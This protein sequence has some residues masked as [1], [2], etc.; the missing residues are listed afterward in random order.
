MNAHRRYL[1][2]VVS[3]V[4]SLDLQLTSS[5]RAEVMHLVDHGEPAEGL[6]TLA[7]IIHDESKNPKAATLE[8]L[9]ELIDGLVETQHLPPTIAAMRGA[10]H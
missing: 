4:D 9:M 8:K 3:L 7:W 2:Q 1:D 10:A 6:C 5:E